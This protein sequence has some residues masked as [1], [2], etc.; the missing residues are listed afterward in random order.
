[1]KA[2]I[3]PIIIKRPKQRCPIHKPEKTHKV[4]KFERI[5]KYKNDWKD[6]LV[7]ETVE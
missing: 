1:M 3:E 5:T 4:R 6:I 7:E 2:K